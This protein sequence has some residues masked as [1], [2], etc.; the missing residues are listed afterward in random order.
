MFLLAVYNFLTIQKDARENPFCRYLSPTSWCLIT[1][2]NLYHPC[3]WFHYL[4]FLPC[5]QIAYD[6]TFYSNIHYNITYSKKATHI[7]NLFS[8]VIILFFLIY[9][10]IIY[11]HNKWHFFSI[12]NRPSQQSSY[13]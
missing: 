12:H 8:S 5:N 4:I 13:C 2:Y 1:L 11:F 3:R 6:H 10:Y 9:S 7:I